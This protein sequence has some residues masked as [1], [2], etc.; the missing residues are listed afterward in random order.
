VIHKLRSLASLRSQAPVKIGKHVLGLFKGLENIMFS[1]LREVMLLSVV[2]QL[3][4]GNSGQ[5]LYACC[6]G[7]RA[8]GQR[9]IKSKT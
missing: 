6:L 8:T 5:K 1:R 3:L 9:S 2:K 7:Y 4:Q